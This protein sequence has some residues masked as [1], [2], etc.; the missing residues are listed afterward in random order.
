MKSKQNTMNIK[1]YRLTFTLL[2]VTS[3]FQLI[4]QNKNGIDFYEVG[5]YESAKSYFIKQGVT[6]ATDHYYLGDIYF[7]E[8][9]I[10][11]AKYYFQQGMQLNPENSYIQIGL[12]KLQVAE[13]GSLE[14]LK[15]I[16]GDRKNRKNGLLQTLA[17]EAFF[18]NN[19]EFE[20]LAQLEKAIAADKNNP[21][22]Y[23]LKGDILAAQGKSGEA[24]TFYESAIYFNSAYKPAYVKLALLYENIRTQVA[25]DYLKQ[26]IS[27]HPDYIPG[28]LTYS[29]INYRKGFYP[30]ALRAYRDYLQLI[31]PNAQDYELY[32]TILY[33]NGMYKDAIE[34]IE[35]APDNLVMNRLKTY[36][37][38][39]LGSYEAALESANRF[40]GIAN[41]SDIITQD[42]TY[43]AQI[44]TRNERFDE[45][46]DAYIKAYKSDNDNIEYLLEAAKA[47]ER[48]GNYDNAIIYYTQI[49][50]TKSD[51]SMADYYTLGAAYYNAGTASDSNTDDTE[52]D[53]RKKR[54]Y[55]LGADKTFG[56]MIDLYPNHYLS[57]LM[58]ARANFALDPEAEEGL[59]VPY[60]TKALE[61]MLSDAETRKGDILE[62]YR[63]LGF[64]HLG[65]NDSTQAKYFWNKVLEH[66][67]EDETALQVIKSLN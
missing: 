14:Q 34:A 12:A 10:D 30:E 35:L 11:S 39:E 31:D 7:K 58:R 38:F 24:A 43:Y 45:S 19:L 42:Y 46:A 8:G 63:Y 54:E 60:Y 26:L 25:F 16:A 62:S 9:V 53:K 61:I 65:K 48:A 1:I 3:A 59:A 57:Y 36:S 64:Y 4:G 50:E 47:Y 22:S 27:Q 29:E 33:F 13:S 21:T 51:L 40:F 17:A 2:M 56:A 66:D 55:L 32:A 18:D 37:F 6:D 23:S 49:L 52:E 15:K 28:L 20:G 67:P 5:D 41:E 44:L